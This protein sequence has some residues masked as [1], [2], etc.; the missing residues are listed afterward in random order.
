MYCAHIVDSALWYTI[1]K[2][3]LDEGGNHDL[4]IAPHLGDPNTHFFDSIEV[5]TPK[6][7]G[8]FT[9]TI[10]SAMSIATSCSA[11]NCTTNFG[12]LKVVGFAT[13]DRQRLDAVQGRVNLFYSLLDAASTSYSDRVRLPKH[14]NIYDQ[15]TVL[16]RQ[17]GQDGKVQRGAPFQ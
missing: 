7:E 1:T 13:F 14:V 6:N 16:L 2:P 3:G 15:C 10:T 8:F 9:A 11:I 5:N 4:C 17:T 12:Q